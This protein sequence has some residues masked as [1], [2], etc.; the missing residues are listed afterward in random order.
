MSLNCKLSKNKREKTNRVVGMI[1]LEQLI[2]RNRANLAEYNR[3]TKEESV[4]CAE[5]FYKNLNLEAQEYVFHMRDKD[6]T[7]NYNEDGL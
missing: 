7:K 2:K 3:L 4:E 1:Y 6:F 5:V